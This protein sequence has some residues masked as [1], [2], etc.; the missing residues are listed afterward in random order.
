MT[1]AARPRR[2][3]E[4]VGARDWARSCWSA[5]SGSRSSRSV[6]RALPLRSARRRDRLASP[7]RGGAGRPPRRRCARAPRGRRRGRPQAHAARGEERAP[8]GAPARPKQAVDQVGS[9]VRHAAPGATRAHTATEARERDE[10][11]VAAGVTTR[12]NEAVR[13][14]S[15]AKV[16]SGDARSRASILSGG[17]DRRSALLFRDPHAIAPV[18]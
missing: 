10:Q 9:D 15:A 13:E 1:L 6:A 8:I 16:R 3:E 17:Q 7:T 11:V 5:R 2:S 18:R 4:S 12:A 14:H